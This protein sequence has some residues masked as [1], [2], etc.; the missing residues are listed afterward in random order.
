LPEFSSSAYLTDTLLSR[1]KRTP[2]KTKEDLLRAA[3]ELSHAYA[4]WLPDW[5]FN[6]DAYEFGE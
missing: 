4:M 5:D 3:D 6:S 2:F 1:L